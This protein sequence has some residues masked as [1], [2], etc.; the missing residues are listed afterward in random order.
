MNKYEEYV[1]TWWIFQV[2]SQTHYGTGL[3]PW[4]FNMSCGNI[5]QM[6]SLD[7]LW[8][9]IDGVGIYGV[10][11]LTKGICN[12]A[13]MWNLEGFCFDDCLGHTQS[14]LFWTAHIGRTN[15][16]RS[17]GHVLIERDWKNV[18]I[19]VIR[20]QI[21]FNI[22]MYYIFY[23]K[24]FGLVDFNIWFMS[25]GKD[26]I[27]WW[28]SPNEKEVWQKTV[29]KNHMSSHGAMPILHTPPPP[30][31]INNFVSLGG[32]FAW[33]WA[34]P[35]KNW[36]PETKFH[37]CWDHSQLCWTTLTASP[38]PQ[39]ECYMQNMNCHWK[40]RTNISVS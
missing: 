30:S 31:L 21:T 9:S 15:T 2:H 35:R 8:W 20:M 12:V 3:H 25:C 5:F 23:K 38:V 1:T 19:V 11:I 40:D 13:S 24:D 17:R 26:K 7:S 16:Q 4:G 18:D 22:L 34:E 39:D 32:N 28:I 29:V 10:G 6:Y 14:S 37:N 33:I 36:S 27:N